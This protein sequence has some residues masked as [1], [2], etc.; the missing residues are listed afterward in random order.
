MQQ[1]MLYM[2]AGSNLFLFL[3]YAAAG[4]VYN[5]QQACHEPWLSLPAVTA[6]LQEMHGL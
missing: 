3:M 1:I 5:P 4:F 2:S 6:K